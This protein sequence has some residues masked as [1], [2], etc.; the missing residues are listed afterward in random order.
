MTSVVDHNASTTVLVRETQQNTSVQTAAGPFNVTSD[1]NVQTILLDTFTKKFQRHVI[2]HLWWTTTLIMLCLQSPKE[3]EI[4]ESRPWGRTGS[5][6]ASG[7]CTARAGKEA[8]CKLSVQHRHKRKR[9]GF[10]QSGMW[11][12]TCSV[13]HCQGSPSYGPRES[14]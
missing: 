1:R 7:T 12:E 4:T 5:C 11:M 9:S 10:G 6:A 13:T 8:H 2:T 3:K 14:A